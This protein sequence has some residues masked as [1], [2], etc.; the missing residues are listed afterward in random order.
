VLIELFFARYYGYSATSENRLNI[1]V[2]AQTGPVW[3]KISGR[4]SRPT[5][6]SSCQKTSM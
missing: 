4:R 2:F 5:N 1:D 6:H 3:P